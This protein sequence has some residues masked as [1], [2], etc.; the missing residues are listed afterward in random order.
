M[1]MAYRNTVQ[2]LALLA[3]GTS[4][5]WAARV[6]SDLDGALM[7]SLYRGDSSAAVS[8]ID[9]GAN[10]NARNAE[11]VPAL[12]IAVLHADRRAVSML[13]EHGADVNARSGLGRTAL[14]AAASIPGNSDTV[15]MLLGAG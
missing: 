3:V 11:G 12:T 6:D 4:A 8:M 2:A 10:A 13:I 5:G 1:D 7:D 9:R 14:I 15:K